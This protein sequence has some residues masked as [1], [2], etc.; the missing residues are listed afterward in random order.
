MA[1]YISLSDVMSCDKT[2]LKLN[3]IVK[4][5]KQF[6]VKNMIF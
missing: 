3:D 2:V 1:V 5:G 6:I 4:Q